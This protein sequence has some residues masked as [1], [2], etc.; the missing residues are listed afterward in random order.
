MI[1]WLS[2]ACGCESCLFSGTQGRARLVGFKRKDLK[3]PELV[4]YT[5]P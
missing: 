1:L 2:Q 3:G 4:V 5:V